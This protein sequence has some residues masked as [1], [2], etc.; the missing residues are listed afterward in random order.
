MCWIRL[1]Y[2]YGVR[3]NI[4]AHAAAVDTETTIPEAVYAV[5]RWQCL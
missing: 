1:I 5:Q 2:T 3:T 4:Q